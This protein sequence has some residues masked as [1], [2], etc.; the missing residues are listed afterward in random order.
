[1]CGLVL[2]ERQGSTHSA[3][4][5]QR[6]TLTVGTATPRVSRMEFILIV[7]PPMRPACIPSPHWRLDD[8]GALAA[9]AAVSNVQLT[10]R[11]AERCYLCNN[12]YY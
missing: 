1:M 9:A 6:T 10:T 8:G 2:Q 4:T 12:N 5:P 3:A 7:T 11:R